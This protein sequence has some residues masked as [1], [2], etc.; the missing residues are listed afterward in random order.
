MSRPKPFR[1]KGMW[2]IHYDF[3]LLVESIWR[4]PMVSNAVKRVIGKLWIVKVALNSW[5]F[6]TF[7]NL[8]NDV[9]AVRDKLKL[10]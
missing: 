3:K 2:N 9:T 6:S 8:I 10:I 7:G 4:T 5:K 1:Y